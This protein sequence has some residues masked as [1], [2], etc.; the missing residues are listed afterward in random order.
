M[1]DRIWSSAAAHL[2]MLQVQV[3]RAYINDWAV[4]S[5]GSRGMS[6]SNLS[7]LSGECAH[8]IRG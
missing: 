4:C 7:M 3:Q 8:L 1:G 6:K 5:D 2:R